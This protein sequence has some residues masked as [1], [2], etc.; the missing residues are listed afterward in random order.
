MM[1]PAWNF[2]GL[3]GSRRNV[4]QL[5]QHLC[6]KHLQL[7][8]RQMSTEATVRT[9]AECDV[10]LVLALDVELLGFGKFLRI[11]IRAGQVDRDPLVLLDCI[12][13]ELGV[14]RDASHRNSERV[15]TQQ[16]L[17]RLGNKLRIGAQFVLEVRILRKMADAEADA[18]DDGIETGDEQQHA[19]VLHQLE[20]HRL[21]VD[22]RSAT[23]G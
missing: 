10:H 4:G 18:V 1:L 14:F 7:D 12:A 13:A 22:L 2:T 23:A 9:C 11:Q 3:S 8:A 15:A 6:V 21:A 16:F 19:V 17:G 5:L 20:R